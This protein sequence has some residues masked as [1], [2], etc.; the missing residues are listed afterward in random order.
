MNAR[1]E[2][3]LDAVDRAYD[4]RS[5]HGP[6]LRGSLRGVDAAMAARRPAPGRH[7][8]WEEAV[9]CAYWKYRVAYQLDESAPRAFD[10]TGSNWIERPAGAA[11]RQAWRTDLERLEAWHARLRASIEG[12]D[13]R[14]LDDPVGSGEFTY[15]G[16]IAGIAAHD[17]YHAGQIRLIR[18]LVEERG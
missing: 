5:W 4:V 15:A 3:L 14:R 6:N 12:F 18:R 10:E 17:H 2:T 1:L 11:T 7:N 16:V 8:I 9:H 13:P